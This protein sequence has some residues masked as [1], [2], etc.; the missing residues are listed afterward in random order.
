MEEEPVKPGYVRVYEMMNW[1]KDIPEAEYW[2]DYVDH[3]F[4]KNLREEIFKE[5]DKD[6]IDRICKKALNP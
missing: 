3:P 4:V 6:I 2:R 1:Y 5:I